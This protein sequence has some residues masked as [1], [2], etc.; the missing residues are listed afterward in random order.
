MTRY[1][2]VN[3]PVAEPEPRGTLPLGCAGD[4]AAAHRTGSAVGRARLAD[5][6]LPAGGVSTA[7]GGDVDVVVVAV[8]GS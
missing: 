8:A 4:S 5:V 1:V 2:L 7:M 3:P 6:D